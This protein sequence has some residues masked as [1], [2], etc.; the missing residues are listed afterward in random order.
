MVFLGEVGVAG[1]GAGG[2]II[3]NSEVSC[4]KYLLELTQDLPS[5]TAISTYTVHLTTIQWR[6]ECEDALS[7]GS[8]EVS[9]A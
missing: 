3:L 6:G 2:F 5:A 4:L 1:G 8:G 9:Q 7:D